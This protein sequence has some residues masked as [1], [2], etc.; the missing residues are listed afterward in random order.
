MAKR[1]I[2]LKQQQ[3]SQ[4]AQIRRIQGMIDDMRQSGFEFRQSFLNSLKVSGSTPS[5]AKEKAQR[6]KGITKTDLYNQVKSYRTDS[7]KLWTGKDAGKR[8][9]LAEQRK[10]RQARKKPLSGLDNVEIALISMEDSFYKGAQRTDMP[11]AKMAVLEAWFS[12]RAPIDQRG[13]FNEGE[14]E[15][16]AAVKEMAEGMG[17]RYQDK[18]DVEAKYEAIFRTLTGGKSLS[19]HML[20][21]YEPMESDVLE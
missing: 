13:Y 17:E 18:D 1:K 10:R 14:P 5:A 21:V 7:G 2:S 4:T 15:T 20:T 3:N 9:R 12:F 6:L 19:T 16:A 8:G 11:Q